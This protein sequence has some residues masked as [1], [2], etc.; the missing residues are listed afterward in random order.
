MPKRPLALIGGLLLIAIV[1]YALST[2]INRI[3]AA[4]EIYL[5][6]YPLVLMENTRKAFMDDSSYPPNHFVHSRTFPDHTF[7]TVVRP[8]RDTLYSVAWLDLSEQ[9]VVLSVP[10]IADRYYVMPFM[11]MWTNVFDAVGTRKTGTAAGKYLISGPD[12]D[13]ELPAGLTKIVSPTQVVWLIGRLQVHSEKDLNNALALQSSFK[14]MS[15][16]EYNTESWKDDILEF[17]TDAQSSNPA[18]ISN[19]L[20]ARD[21]LNQLMR[22]MGT[23]HS[24][25]PVDKPMLEKIS[26]FGLLPDINFDY[27]SLNP[28]NRFILNQAVSLTQNQLRPSIEASVEREL[29]NGWAMRTQG[30]GRYGSDYQTRAAIANI[31]LAALPSEEAIYANTTTDGNGELLSGDHSYRI[32]FGAGALPPAN[33]F[34]SLTVYD[35][36]GYLTANPIGRYA[37]KSRDTLDINQDGSTTILLQHEPPKETTNWLPIPKEPFAVTLRMYLPD[38]TLTSG[39]WQPPVISR[40]GY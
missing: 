30:I 29:I 21:F 31:A 20:D 28:W 27:A 33:A 34:W 19:A 26:S 24:I 37:I 17:P 23:M 32:E 25:S 39:Q 11:D 5:Y 40:D 13:H 10:E 4:S 6:G 15:L 1:F 12:C 18:A 8:N 16:Q 38:E 2:T 36:N 7:R 3:K 9:P 14:L 35:E 22:L